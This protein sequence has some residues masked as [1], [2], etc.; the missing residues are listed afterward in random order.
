MVEGSASALSRAIGATICSTYTRPFCESQFILTTRARCRTS[1][2]VGD[3]I[4]R[5]DSWVLQI[6][7]G[8]I[9]DDIGGIERGLDELE[10]ERNHVL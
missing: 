8:K 2:L 3:S 4:S 5:N 7:P 10:L 1:C 6:M 9:C